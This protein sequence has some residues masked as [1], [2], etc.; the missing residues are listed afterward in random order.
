MASRKFHY[1]ACTKQM[2]DSNTR[3]ALVLNG[4]KK[5]A[6]HNLSLEIYDC[7]MF[8]NIIIVL[9]CFQVYDFQ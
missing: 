2:T 8:V 6:Q 3:T 9:T 7:L 5:I 4:G 1:F